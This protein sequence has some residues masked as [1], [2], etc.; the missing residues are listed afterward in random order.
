MTG[1]N[2]KERPNMKQLHEEEEVVDE[3]QYLGQILLT[4]ASFCLLAPRQGQCEVRIKCPAV[5]LCLHSRELTE[6]KTFRGINA[7][8]VGKKQRKQC[9]PGSRARAFVFSR[10][11]L[12]NP[13]SFFKNPDYSEIE[14]ISYNLL[15]ILVTGVDNAIWCGYHIVIIRVLVIMPTHHYQDGVLQCMM[16]M[17]R[18]T[19][20]IILCP[21]KECA[22]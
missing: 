17:P 16:I 13:I 1:V 6:E 19:Q 12:G 7:R 2:T 8:T 22:V 20:R 3:R 15:S 10:P 11:F 18:I 9:S 5:L 14:Y 4:F 21:T